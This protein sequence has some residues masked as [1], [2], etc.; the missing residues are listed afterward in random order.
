MGWHLTITEVGP[1]FSDGT[2]TRRCFR[3]SKRK[4]QENSPLTP[5]RVGVEQSR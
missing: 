5:E 4:K 3:R 1:R 2:L